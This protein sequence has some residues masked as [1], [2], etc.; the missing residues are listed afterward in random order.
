[1]KYYGCIQCKQVLEQ[2]D[3]I[4]IVNPKWV[5]KPTDPECS[6]CCKDL[7]IELDQSGD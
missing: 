4:T 3:L 7:A 2:D 5:M 6:P 1:M